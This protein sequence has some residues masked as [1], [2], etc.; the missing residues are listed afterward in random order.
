VPGVV[1]Y[2]LKQVEHTLGAAHAEAM[3]L[4]TV[5]TPALRPGPTALDGVDVVAL[6]AP[7]EDL[8]EI[9]MLSLAH[10][11]RLC[12]GVPLLSEPKGGFGPQ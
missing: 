12:P 7:Q 11:D 2:I 4:Y 1:L 9:L 6:T 10:S 5:A 8:G 3:T